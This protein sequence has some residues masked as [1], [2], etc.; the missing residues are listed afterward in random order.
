MSEFAEFATF[1]VPAESKGKSLENRFFRLA[2]GI[3]NSGPPVTR[4]GA[5]P[6]STC[7]NLAAVGES[8]PA[9]RWPRDSLV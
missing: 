7:Q 9:D 2:T 8:I 6:I 5:G 4:D 1:V 3:E